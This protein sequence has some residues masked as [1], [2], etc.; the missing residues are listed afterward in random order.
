LIDAPSN[1]ATKV[2]TPVPYS[3]NA[4]NATSYRI[5]AARDLGFLQMLKDTIVNVTNPTI[6]LPNGTIVYTK[7]IGINANGSGP[8]SVVVMYTTIKAKPT[9]ESVTFPL[10]NATEVTQPT[11]YTNSV[12]A[13]AEKHEWQLLDIYDSIMLDTI[14]TNPGFTY[15]K[16]PTNKTFKAKVRGINTDQTGDWSQTIIYTMF[17]YAPSTFD[18]NL[19]NN[20]TVVY[21]IKKLAI[22]ST[23]ATDVDNN[24]SELS[25]NFHI[26]GPSID[27]IMHANNIETIY[28]DSARLKLDSQYTVSAEVTDGKKTTP[29][30]ETK[31]FKTP[32]ATTGIE[33][34]FQ[35][36]DFL[37]Y[38]NPTNY[39][40]T[41]EYYLL[42]NLKIN[43]YLYNMDG[44][45]LIC[46][47]F[48]KTS[49]SQSRSINLT[50]IGKG[51]FILKLVTLDAGK[52][53]LIKTFKL[54]RN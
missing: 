2:G 22:P 39:D 35:G 47:S 11:N 19:V 25:K 8:E 23:P 31:T 15:D 42:Q 20:A 4:P 36:G 21:V 16:L 44:K 38:P 28:L 53:R 46:Q 49:G 14:P 10:N 12:G 43:I 51:I 40:I 48:D 37:I 1:N 24:S 18:I 6:P 52:E 54:I 30:N 17:D 45:K 3:V 32:K 29:A 34:I 7:A 33:N 50:L 5:L 41:L 13:N 9:S 27:T 26:T